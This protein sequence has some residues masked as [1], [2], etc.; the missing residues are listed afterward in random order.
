M[1]KCRK[2]L[3]TLNYITQ[4]PPRI[5]MLGGVSSAPIQYRERRCLMTSRWVD[6]PISYEICKDYNALTAYQRVMSP[7][8][9][10]Y[11]FLLF[12]G[13][14]FQTLTSTPFPPRGRWRAQGIGLSGGTPV[15]SSTRGIPHGWRATRRAAGEC[16]AMQLPSA[17]RRSGAIGASA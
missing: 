4:I 11:L 14:R 2:T 5:W 1:C 13:L 10:R 9:R 16:A 8:N 15:Y 6:G 7:R 3:V 12:G 17:E